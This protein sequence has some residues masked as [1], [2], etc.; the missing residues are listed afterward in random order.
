MM[1]GAW[2]QDPLIGKG[3]GEATPG[4]RLTLPWVSG[5]L[6]GFQPAAV[7]GG[8]A[9]LIGRV[10]KQVRDTLNPSMEG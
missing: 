6:P 7:S 8:K 4:L 5:S 3:Q 1:N 10:Q 9:L 2:V